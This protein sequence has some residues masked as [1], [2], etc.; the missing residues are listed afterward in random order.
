MESALFS[1]DLTEKQEENLIDILSAGVGKSLDNLEYGSGVD[2][3]LRD[4]VSNL[5]RFAE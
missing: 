3:Q 5:T 1:Y 4:I 2:Q